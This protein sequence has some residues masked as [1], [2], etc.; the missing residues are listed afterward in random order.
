MVKVHQL[1]PYK[2]GEIT[3]LG[4]RDDATA[5]DL[6]SRIALQV[7]PLLRT[8]RFQVL[9]LRG[10]APHNSFLKLGA[11]SL[12]TVTLDPSHSL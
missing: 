12:V 7:Q 2:V 9:H 11:L 6:L 4:M 3:T 8:R 1:D 5:R 10:T